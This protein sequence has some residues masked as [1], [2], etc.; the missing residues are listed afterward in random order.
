MRDNT[1]VDISGWILIAPLVIT[2]AE[3]AKVFWSYRRSGSSRSLWQEWNLSIWPSPFQFALSIVL[4]LILTVTLGVF[5]DYRA[6]RKPSPAVQSLAKLGEIDALLRDINEQA[7]LAIAGLKEPA[8]SSAILREL[9]DEI[10]LQREEI[11][12]L[13]DNLDNGSSP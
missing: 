10:G 8:S 4:I 2:W 7:A 11:R 9:L 6:S 13:V 5:L 12:R 3:L 1:R